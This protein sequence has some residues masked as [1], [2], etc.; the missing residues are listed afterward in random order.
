MQRKLYP[1]PPTL[2]KKSQ[3]ITALK[4][5]IQP[6]SVVDEFALG[7]YVSSGK[8]L[9]LAMSEKVNEKETH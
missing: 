2:L 6:G 9:L 7:C 4:K 1:P 5:V 3:C 8:G